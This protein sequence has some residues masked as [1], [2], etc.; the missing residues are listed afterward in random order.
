MIM[1]ILFSQNKI[2][3]DL[4]TGN[5]VKKVT[6]FSIPLVLGNLFAQFYSITDAAIVGSFVGI[7]AFAA[8]GSTSW[9]IWFLIAFCR[10]ASNT[11]CALA[12]FRVGNKNISDLRK[13]TI[14]SNVICVSMCVVMCILLNIFV[15]PVLRL[16]QVD[17][18]IYEQARTYLM[19]YVFSTPFLMINNVA[20]AILRAKG[21]SIYPFVTMAVAAFTNIVLDLVFVC[22]LHTGVKGAVWATFIA[23]VLSAVTAVAWLW[24]TREQNISASGH[25]LSVRTFL[26]E[27]N[28]LFFSM[29]ANSIMITVGGL[30]VQS[31]IN[32]LGA[33]FTA[34]TTAGVKVFDLLEAIIMAIMSGLSVF[35]GQNLGA[36]QISY[37]KKGVRNMVFFGLILTAVM[38]LL[39]WIFETPIVSFFLKADFTS[40]S[41]EAFAVAYRYIRLITLGMLIM[42]PLY[43]IRV[44]VQ[45]MGYPV[46]AFIAGCLQL[47]ARIICV[48]FFPDF[49]GTDA[50]YLADVFAWMVSLPLLATAYIVLSRR[51]YAFDRSYYGK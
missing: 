28:G 23:Q 51:L 29:V 17:P 49:L 3:A 42:T 38:I 21:Y 9:V 7:N 35:V 26:H 12:S 4:L 2:P 27:F 31:K 15:D 32:S 40:T 19:I 1:K 8:I 48:T 33:A 39:V 22:V 10:D 20:C 11:V 45:T 41:K 24:S 50:Y 47:G 18:V 25:S 34:G 37:M 13:I 36:K 6:F 44:T 43:F 5:P 46:Y 16:L 14:Y 30:F